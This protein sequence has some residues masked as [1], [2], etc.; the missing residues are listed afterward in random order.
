LP[1]SLEL[2]LL[3]DELVGIV[4]DC[5]LMIFRDGTLRIVLIEFCSLRNAVSP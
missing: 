5:T 2:V 4:R 3:D 1:S